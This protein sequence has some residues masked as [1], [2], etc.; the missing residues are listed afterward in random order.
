MQKE[1]IIVFIKSPDR[2]RVKSR[3][4]ESIGKER[5]RILYRY[6]VEDLL[7]TLTGQDVHLRLYFEP[8]DAKDDISR[9]LGKQYDLFPQRGADLGEKMKQAFE[10]TFQQGYRSVLLIGSDVPDLTAGIFK[11]GFDALSI[12]DA[13]LGPSMDGGYYLIGFRDETF[14]PEIFEGIP[15]STNVVFQ[16]TLEVFIALGDVVHILPAWRDIDVIEDLKALMHRHGESPFRQSR[17]MR[18]LVSQKDFIR[19]D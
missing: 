5:A 9:W 4:A 13:L 12:H 2:A 15:W 6:F 7:D 16:K 11:E 3:L 1:A 8:H 19:Q 17:T 14:R 10:E 18:Y